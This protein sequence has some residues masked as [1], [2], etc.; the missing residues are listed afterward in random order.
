MTNNNPTTDNY[1]ALVARTDDGGK[2]SAAVENADS[3]LLADG[4]A[5]VRVQWSGI[6]YKDALAVTG[7]G[8]ILR[9]SPLIPGIDF[10]GTLAE[11]AAGMPAGTAVALTGRGVG[12]KYSGG[13]SQ[14]ARTKSAWLSPLPAQINARQAMICGTA[15]LT[16]ALC[17]LALQDGGHV[18]KG[19]KIAV[20]GASGGVGSFAVRL[21]AKLGYEVFAVSRPAAAEYL[22]AAGA[23]EVLPRE[24]MSAPPRPL[25]KSRWDGAIDTVGG[26]LLAR[27]L[28]ETEYGGVVAACGLAA[29]HKLETTV[30]PFI[31]RGVR[32][33]GVDSVMIPDSLRARAWQLLAETLADEDYAAVENSVVGLDGVAAAAEKVLAGELNGRIVVSPDGNV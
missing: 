7:K 33:D 2:V 15:G 6:N 31:L 25:E 16:A 12:E 24:E 22:K 19:G 28:A 23:A 32:L 18:K 4:D 29:S 11:D 27:L 20:S 21:L 30:M 14:F 5:T 26:V 1:R 3:E 9:A 8:K 17:V 13:F 10:A